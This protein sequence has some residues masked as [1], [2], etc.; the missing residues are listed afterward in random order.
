MTGD[1][2]LYGGLRDVASRLDIGTML[3]HLG[4]VRFRYLTGWFRYTMDARQGAELLDLV[5][6]SAVVPVHYEGWSHFQQGR[7]R[8]RAGA[9]RVTVRRPHHVGRSRAASTV[10]DA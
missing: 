8:R 10:V 2:V 3:M 6:P 9:R 1:T 4:S 5:K 7:A